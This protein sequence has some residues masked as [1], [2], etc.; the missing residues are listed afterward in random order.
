MLTKLGYHAHVA[1]NGLE[2]LAALERQH[3]DIIFMDMQMPEMDGVAA[4]RRIVER[5]PDPDARPWIIALTANAT[6]GD[7]ERCL[8]AGM[9]DFLSKPMKTPDLAAALARVRLAP[10]VA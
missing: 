9:D 7:R 8:A 6:D 4:T 10:L 5:C 3:Y 1:A 2:V